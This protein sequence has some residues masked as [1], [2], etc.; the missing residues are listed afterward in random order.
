M[1]HVVP[2]YVLP[3]ARR[4]VVE[5]GY[6]LLQHTVLRRFHRTRRLR[7]RR[8]NNEFRLPR[9]WGA[10]ARE[11]AMPGWARAVALDGWE[12]AREVRI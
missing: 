9:N 1:V 8:R 11:E 4:L 2:P 5:L 10:R 12:L 3:H 6:A 7:R